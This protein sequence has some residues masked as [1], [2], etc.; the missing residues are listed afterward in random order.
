[1]EARLYESPALNGVLRR[2][3]GALGDLFEAERLVGRYIDPRLVRAD[4]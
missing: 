3:R 1:M 4:R 2:P